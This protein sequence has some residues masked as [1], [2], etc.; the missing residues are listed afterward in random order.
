M[1]LTANVYGKPVHVH[2]VLSYETEESKFLFSDPIPF[3]RVTLFNRF[4]PIALVPLVHLSITQ[5]E[6]I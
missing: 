4:G 6:T 2:E 3:V 1:N 5:E